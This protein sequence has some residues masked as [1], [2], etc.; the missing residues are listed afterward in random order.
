MARKYPLHCACRACLRPQISRTVVANELNR[1]RLNVTF[2]CE[3]IK[4]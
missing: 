1:E 3:R 2:G 4:I